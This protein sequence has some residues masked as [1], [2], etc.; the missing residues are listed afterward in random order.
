MVGADKL[1][2][3]EW[4]KSTQNENQSLGIHGLS[5][6]ERK[7]RKDFEVWEHQCTLLNLIE[8]GW[9]F[10]DEGDEVESDLRIYRRSGTDCY[11]DVGIAESVGCL[12]DCNRQG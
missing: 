6:T 10:G 11:S 2:W 3:L 8:R 7:A 9:D 4:N 1:L 5:V 12:E